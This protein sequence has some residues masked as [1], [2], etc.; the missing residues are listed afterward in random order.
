MPLIID[1][2]NL[3]GHL[4][5]LSLADADDEQALVERLRRYRAHTRQGIVV[6]FDRGAPAGSAPSLSG[7]GVEVV[8]ARVGHTADALI[9]ERLRRE[10]HPQSWT[11]VTADRDL[12]AQARGLRAHVLAPEDFIRRLAAPRRAP[13][14]LKQRQQGGEAGEKPSA[15]GDVEEWM[16]LF[17][18]ARSLRPRRR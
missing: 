12:A 16:R 1:G 8:F 18:A 13:P 4:S 10:R 11:V 6:V 14:P 5:D 2:H 15:V 9:L 17:G 7:G 3:I